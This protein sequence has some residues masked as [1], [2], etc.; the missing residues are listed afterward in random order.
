MRLGIALVLCCCTTAWATPQKG[1]LP[2][3]DDVEAAKAHFAAGSA[4]YDQANYADAVKEFNEAYR[5]SKRTDLLYNIAVCYE[6][7]GDLDGA[8][9]A[10]RKYLDDKP[11]APDRVTILSRI[12]NLERRKREVGTRP[13][14]I[15]VV[16]PTEPAPPV[17]EPPQRR[18]GKHWYVAGTALMAVGVGFAAI[19]LGT[20]LTAHGIH[21]RLQMVCPNMTCPESERGNVERGQALGITSD[22]F[23]GLGIAAGVG[24]IVAFVVQSRPVRSS[25]ALAVRF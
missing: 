24:G 11:E 8:I 15:P 4:Y 22:V 16:Q 23:F 5:L 14:P 2:P 13:A 20:G 21:D 12:N 25:N 19:S 18:G 6:R 1:A 17:V 10:L 9:N 3:A 7:L